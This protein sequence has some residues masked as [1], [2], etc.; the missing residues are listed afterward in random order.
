MIVENMCLHASASY[1][2]G[3]QYCWKPLTDYQLWEKIVTEMSLS[4]LRYTPD[5]VGIK[6]AKL[7]QLNNVNRGCYQVKDFL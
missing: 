4:I 7:Q 5:P 6:R 3:A 2:E 1:S